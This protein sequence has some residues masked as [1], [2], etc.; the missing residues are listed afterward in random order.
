MVRV[1]E[2]HT[3]PRGKEAWN[4]TT[5]SLGIL[6]IEREISKKQFKESINKIM[7]IPEAVLWSYEIESKQ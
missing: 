2:G 7:E 6:W 4:Q 1:W 5:G 3:F